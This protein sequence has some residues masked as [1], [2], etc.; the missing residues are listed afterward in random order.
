MSKTT[1]YN[2][3]FNAHKGQVRKYTGEPY[4]HHP[5][6]VMTCLMDLY[7]EATAT[8]L[9][10]A[11]LHDVVEDTTATIDDVERAFGTRVAELVDWLTDISKPE[12]G[13]RRRRKAMDRKHTQNAPFEAQLIKCADLIDNT[14]SIVEHDPKFAKT[15]LAEKRL[16]LDVMRDEVKKTRIWETASSICKVSA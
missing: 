9:R 15:Y 1:T 6:A 2:F 12:D 13:N 8:M 3:A 16:L 11:L 7:P 14:S 10:A 4:I 5:Q